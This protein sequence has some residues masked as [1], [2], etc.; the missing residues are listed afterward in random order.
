MMRWRGHVERGGMRKLH[1]WFWRENPKE[2]DD[3]EKKNLERGRIIL[4]PIFK[5]Q[6]SRSWTGFVWLRFWI[7]WL[8]VV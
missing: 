7:S 1:S 8:A 4:K 5:K 6:D 3:F 2:R